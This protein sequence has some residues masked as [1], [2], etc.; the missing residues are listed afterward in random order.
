MA[1]GH[2]FVDDPKNLACLVWLFRKLTNDFGHGPTCPESFVGGWFG[3]GDSELL[4]GGRL[5]FLHGSLLMR[6]VAAW[7]ASAIS[8]CAYSR[9]V[10]PLGTGLHSRSTTAAATRSLAVVAIGRNGSGMGASAVEC[11]NLLAS[12]E[13]AG[14]LVAVVSCQSSGNRRMRSTL[15]SPHSLC[16]W[17][18]SSPA[19]AAAIAAATVGLASVVG[20]IIFI[21]AGFGFA[22]GHL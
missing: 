7:I 20:F 6:M 4:D 10:H 19:S 2:H 18:L 8:R 17:R 12:A 11:E 9:H 1:E 15:V 22:T 13:R 5:S 21:V 3:W 14:D 16:P